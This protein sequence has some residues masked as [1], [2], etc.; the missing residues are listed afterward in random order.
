MRVNTAQLEKLIAYY[1]L[2]TICDRCGFKDVCDNHTASFA[3]CKKNLMELMSVERGTVLCT[4]APTDACG[5]IKWLG[6]ALAYDCIY[7][8]PTYLKPYD[9]VGERIEYYV[10]N[11]K[12]HFKEIVKN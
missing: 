12:K 6:C 3:E 11:D 1:A 10:E 8:I 2:D 5:Y 7:D 9:V 4:S